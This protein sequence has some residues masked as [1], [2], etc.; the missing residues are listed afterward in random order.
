MPWNPTACY[1]NREMR[2]FPDLTALKIYVK[3][4][5]IICEAENKFSKQLIIYNFFLFA[6]RKTEFS[7]FFLEKIT[8]LLLCIKLIREYGAQNCGVRNYYRDSLIF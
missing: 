7:V 5:I 6:K 3:S 8:Q 2:V 4:P 1:E